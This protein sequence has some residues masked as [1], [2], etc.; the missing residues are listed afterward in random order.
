MIFWIL[1]ILGFVIYKWLTSN[2]N[3]YYKLGI[4]FEKPWPVV[5]NNLKILLQKESIND[6]MTRCY[7]KYKASKFFGYFN[8]MSKMLIVTDPG[9]IKKITVK[10]FNHF[11]NHDDALEMDDLL[12][13]SIFALRDKKW[14]DMRTT[15]SPI[16]TSSKMKLMFGLLSDHTR[17]FIKFMEEQVELGNNINVDVGDIFKLYTAD[18]I[19]TAALGFV[20]NSTRDKNSQTCRMIQ[21]LD[22]DFNGTL[23]ALK[24]MLAMGF[25]KIYKFFNIQLVRKEVNEFFK[26]AVLDVMDERERYN[27]SRPDVIQ[28]LLQA[29]K[30]QL[31]HKIDDDVDKEL[32][33]FSAHTELDVSLKHEKM[34]YFEDKDWIAQVFLF[35]GA[36]FD[37]STML[38]Q[39]V[40]YDLADHPDIQEELIAEVDNA[41]GKFSDYFITYEALHKMKFLDMVVSE[42]LRL[43]PAA[44]LTD[45]ICNKDY[46]IDLG[47]GRTLIIPKGEII[48]IPIYQIHHDPEY[49]P[50]PEIFNPYRFNDESS[51]I[52]G[53]YLPFGMGARICK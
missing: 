4:P 41:R 9:L 39:S 13:R 38:L 37:T 53:T 6:I 49:Y 18:G 48:G 50:D 30:G 16:F 1:L 46:E 22:N 7:K 17:D 51:I 11:I 14:R 31:E 45:R 20:G 28:L 47:N 12:S 34:S 5:G 2:N 15:L 29:R 43:R 27:I 52:S 25:P 10:D 33:N 44:G 26:R 8:F 19:S 21:Q 42:S 23:G 32:S 24:F 40:C 36:G 35:F 3:Y